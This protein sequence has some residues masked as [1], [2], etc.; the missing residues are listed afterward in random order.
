MEVVKSSVPGFAVEG[1]SRLHA[2]VRSGVSVCVH[3]YL[4]TCL[5][6]K[7]LARLLNN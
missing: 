3:A 2:D 4:H 6:D 5:L 7:T 1:R